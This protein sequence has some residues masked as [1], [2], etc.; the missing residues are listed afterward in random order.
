MGEVGFNILIFR[1]FLEDVNF[2][3]RSFLTVA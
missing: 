2:L 1:D 3:R